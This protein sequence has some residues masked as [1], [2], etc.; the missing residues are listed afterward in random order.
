MAD[1]DS[2]AS[3]RERPFDLENLLAIPISQKARVHIQQDHSDSF[4]TIL[5]PL[6]PRTDCDKGQWLH[7]TFV[8]EI[9]RA[10]TQVL[11][12]SQ[13]R[14]VHQ[15]PYQKL[16]RFSGRASFMAETF[17]SPHIGQTSSMLLDLPHVVVL[18]AYI[19]RFRCKIR[20]E[21]I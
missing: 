1:G 15:H 3:I 20:T 2:S 9:D 5:I 19:G 21:S 14:S 6:L 16:I 12:T 11:R 10:A 17:F 18:P 4:S 13:M 7:I 8:M